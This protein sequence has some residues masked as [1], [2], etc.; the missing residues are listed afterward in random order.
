[1]NVAVTLSPRDYDVV[2]FDL[3]G[4]VLEI[5][6]PRRLNDDATDVGTHRDSTGDT[7]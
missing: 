2:L 5:N 1:M 3:D 7:P 6:D 4:E